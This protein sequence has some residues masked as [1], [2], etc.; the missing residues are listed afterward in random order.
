MKNTFH[1]I[2]GLSD[3]FNN[4][5]FCYLHYL[6]IKSCYLTQDNPLI[7]IHCLYEPV[8]NIWWNKT[9]EFVTV[10]KY[11]KLPDM[12]YSIKNRKV[13]Q[14]EHQADIFR[15]LILKE[16]GGVYAD[17]DTLFYKPF[18]PKF[19]MYD[20]VMGKETIFHLRE[21]E[22]HTNGLCNALIICKKDSEFLKLY[23]DSFDEHFDGY[24][25]NKMAVRV[26][27]ELSKKHS[28]LIHIEPSNSFH[29]FDWNLNFYYKK[30]KNREYDIYSKHLAES[31]VY[32]ILKNITVEK[33]K[34]NNSIFG[35]MCRN[36]K[37]LLDE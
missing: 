15:L 30:M 5:P 34:T 18:F 13:W 28:D 32:D 33:I 36:I 14:I 26:P 6:C 24:D 16:Y 35:R 31:K 21:K 4:K 10:I 11:E 27:Y 22:L 19:E 3:Q 29:K 12:V 17:V 9:K 2:F 20:F 7:K 25:Y 1:F 23:L 8:D 37:G